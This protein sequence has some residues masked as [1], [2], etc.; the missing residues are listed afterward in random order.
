MG[1]M[2]MEIYYQFTQIFKEQVDATYL[3]RPVFYMN[4]MLVRHFL[5]ARDVCSAG[6]A[7]NEAGQYEK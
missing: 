6:C 2:K 1:Y 5:A 3:L 4:E 7:L